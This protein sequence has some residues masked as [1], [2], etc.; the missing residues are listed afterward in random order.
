MVVYAAAT[1][2]FFH[3][4]NQE[5]IGFV[6]F[7]FEKP[8][9]L[10]FQWHVSLC[11]RCSAK[12]TSTTK[13][14]E[15][16]NYIIPINYIIAHKIATRAARCLFS[17]V[18]QTI[19]VHLKL[20][21]SIYFS[22]CLALFRCA[23]FTIRLSW[24]CDQILIHTS[25]FKCVAFYGN[26]PMQKRVRRFGFFSMYIQQRLNVLLQKF[27]IEI[28]AEYNVK[29]AQFQKVGLTVNSWLKMVTLLRYQKNEEKMMIDEDVMRREIAF[30][31]LSTTTKN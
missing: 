1:A 19:T 31:F 24:T 26:K 6:K 30:T 12:S 27:P 23:M 7:S 25:S 10:S 5:F 8:A 14:K 29:P 28:L 9:H 22:L 17:I 18:F 4:L 15:K 21:F 2:A 3:L 16:Q 20:Y 11:K 13:K